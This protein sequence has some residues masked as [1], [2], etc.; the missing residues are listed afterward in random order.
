MILFNLT[1]K[2]RKELRESLNVH[3]QYET[4]KNEPAFQKSVLRG[5]N[6][7]DFKKLQGEIERI[8]TCPLDISTALIDYKKRLNIAF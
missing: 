2:E 3:F 7:I 5:T 6:E 1:F 4:L 8:I